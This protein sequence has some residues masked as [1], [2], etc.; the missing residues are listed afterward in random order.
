MYFLLYLVPKIVHYED[1]RLHN[2]T[3]DYMLKG[4]YKKNTYISISIYL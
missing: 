3:K 1:L 4:K 2:A